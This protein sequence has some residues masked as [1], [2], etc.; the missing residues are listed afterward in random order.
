[1]RLPQAND[2]QRVIASNRA[3]GLETGISVASYPIGG[4][5]AYGLIGW[6]IAT[7]I[8][9][10]WPIP[11]GMLVGLAIG[12]GYVI[13]RYGTQAGSTHKDARKDPRKEMR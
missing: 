9:A 5:V 4:V 2:R 3:A 7:L 13:Y 11:A 6:L 8:H 12:T 1:M 10:E